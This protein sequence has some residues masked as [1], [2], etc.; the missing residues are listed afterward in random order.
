[1][2]TA[3]Y[4]LTQDHLEKWPLKQSVCVCNLLL[5][6]DALHVMHRSHWRTTQPINRTDKSPDKKLLADVL[7]RQTV[8][9]GHV[10][11]EHFCWANMTANKISV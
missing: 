5:F 4:W 1:M 8:V 11:Q 10:S 2:E 6:F 9:S 3:W 7:A